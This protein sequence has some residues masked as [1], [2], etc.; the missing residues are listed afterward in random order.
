[1]RDEPK[2]QQTNFQLFDFEVKYFEVNLMQ[3]AS[4][5]N[6]KKKLVPESL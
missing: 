1:M 5:G 3:W 2:L 6:R 4:L